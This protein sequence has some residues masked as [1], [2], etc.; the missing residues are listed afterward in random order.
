VY[1]D[2]DTGYQMIEYT[3]KDTHTYRHTNSQLDGFP[4]ANDTSA[5]DAFLQI[6][7]LDDDALDT[8]D[9]MPLATFFSMIAFNTRVIL[10]QCYGL[11]T[12]P[13]HAI[14]LMN[15]RVAQGKEEERLYTVALQ[16]GTN[17]GLL[18]EKYA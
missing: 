3:P 12:L 17:V 18:R 1:D 16:T 13:L 2:L 6:P 10:P 7:L 9:E 8:P 5:I 14:H 4:D 15:Q 11:P